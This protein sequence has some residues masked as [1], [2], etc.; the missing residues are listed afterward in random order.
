MAADV[1]PD[2]VGAGPIP[3]RHVGVV[4][5]RLT[6]PVGDPDVIGLGVAGAV[7][8]HEI[9]D[10]RRGTRVGAGLVA[11]GVQLIGPAA[12][13]GQHRHRVRARARV[14]LHVVVD[15]VPGRDA[16]GASLVDGVVG[17]RG[18][19]GGRLAGA[20]RL[21]RSRASPSA[22]QAHVGGNQM[23]S[24]GDLGA[25][26]RGVE[27][28]LGAGRVDSTDVDA[29]SAIRRGRPGVHGGG[30]RGCA[31]VKALACVGG[32]RRVE[33]RV[34]PDDRWRQRGRGV[35]AAWT[36]LWRA[37]GGERELRPATGASTTSP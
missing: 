2:P 1:L 35:P 31:R 6:V 30:R 13:V 15:R 28:R 18:A 23:P 7:L 12:E 5:G 4:G 17:R 26:P 33:G 9:A 24:R 22:L 11:V 10:P 20:D 3:A 14:L 37:D 25:D 16:K 32:R 27:V 34:R 29:D 19:L 36:S 21:A 8:R